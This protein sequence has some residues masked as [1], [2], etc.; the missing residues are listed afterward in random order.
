MAR[1]SIW[2]LAAVAAVGLAHATTTPQQGGD[3]AEGTMLKDLPDETLHKV[4]YYLPDDIENVKLTAKRFH[5]LAVTARDLH[6]GGKVFYDLRHHLGLPVMKG[7]PTLVGLQTLLDGGLLLRIRPNDVKH[8][9]ANLGLKFNNGYIVGVVGEFFK[10]L[11]NGDLRKSFETIADLSAQEPSTIEDVASTEKDPAEEARM[12]QIREHRG[13]LYDLWLKVIDHDE[14]NQLRYYLENLLAY[15][16]IPRII[17][18][19]LE[20]D[21]YE[22]DLKLAKQHKYEMALDL[23]KQLHQLDG[24]KRVIAA[25]PENAPNYYEFILLYMTQQKPQDR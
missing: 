1:I 25:C 13:Y 19:V 8:S 20:S 24:V 14:K 7:S 11:G 6:F 18:Q 4:L 2:L 21:I 15:N 22:I 3:T 23:A 16:V 17:G 5:A 12:L 10:V 9:L